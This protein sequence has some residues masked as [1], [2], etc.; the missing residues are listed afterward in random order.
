MKTISVQSGIA[1]DFDGSIFNCDLDAYNG[2][3]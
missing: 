2:L 3:S 1:C